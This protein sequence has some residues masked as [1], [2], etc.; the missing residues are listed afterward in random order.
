MKKHIYKI[1]I[2]LFC[3]FTIPS[4]FAMVE[5]R[6]GYINNDSVSFKTEANEKGDE[7]LKT[8]DTGDK[9]TLLENNVITSDVEICKQ[10][11]YYVN[12]YWES[13]NQKNYQGYVCGDNITF[14]VDETKYAEEFANAGF[15]ESYFEKL[16][17]LKDAHPN[18]IFT[19]YKTNINWED[20]VTAESIVGENGGISYIQS[21]NPIYLSLEPGSYDP[22]A[23]QYKQ[24]EAGGWYAANKET[25]AYYLDPRNFL[26]QVQIFMF[27][28]LGYNETYQTEEVLENILKDTDLLQYKNFYLESATYNGNSVSPIMLAARSKQEVVLSDG[29]LSGSANG[30]SG[31][32][33]FYN[34]GAFS[35]CAN[36]VECAIAF[37][38]GYEGAYTSYNRPW[39]TPEAS[40][41]NGS[42]YIANGYINKKQNTLYFQKWNVTNNEYGNFSHQYMNNI[43]APA[44]EAKTTYKSY[45]GIE[46]LLSSS[47]E[48]IIPVYENMPEETS[49][50]P[51][52]VDKEEIDKIE[53]EATIV[54]EISTIVN[55]AGYVYNTG[56]IS[57]I[58]TGTTAISMITNLIKDNPN[59]LVTIQTSDA[60]EI[61]GEELIG[62]NYIISINNGSVEETYRIILT[63]DVNGDAIID[64][65]DYVKVYNT[66]K[67]SSNL[68][69]AYKLAADM[70][71]DGEIDILDAVKVYNLKN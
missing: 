15:P 68:N 6:Q 47:I 33:N 58:T 10:G 27:E 46:G 40:I 69:G 61:I 39:T 12:F 62:T 30:E 4:V 54:K 53:E 48:F 5:S 28:N 32:Y 24:M 25:V 38:S 50:L 9:V 41:K 42:Q 35:S 36:P 51:I 56:Y 7:V 55:G 11:Y 26:D 21:S 49:K 18:W 43:A 19:A 8:L 66:T 31:Y 52:S 57:G 20:A 34:L 65:L 67:N 29:K 60:K 16:T 1:T 45:S 37:A 70:N 44:S 23:K 64:I 63:G 2:M 3:F 17:I 22:I 14:E 71:N 13:R 59:V